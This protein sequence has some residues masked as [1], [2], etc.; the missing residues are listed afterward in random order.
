M[1]AFLII[2]GLLV[3][4]LIRRRRPT[5]QMDPPLAEEEHL[6][7]N[8]DP[9][10]GS[11]D[12][13]SVFPTVPTVPPTMSEMCVVVLSPMALTGSDCSPTLP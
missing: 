7:A 9:F 12:R 8:I 3:F 10:V 6:A 5:A 13:P 11:D 2:V 4:W 1:V